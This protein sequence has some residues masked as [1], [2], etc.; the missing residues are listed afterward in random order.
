[1]TPPS[2]D[3]LAKTMAK[4]AWAAERASRAYA[5]AP[6]SADG[7]TLLR[8]YNDLKNARARAQAA[9]EAYFLA[10]EQA[11]AGAA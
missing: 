5:Q 9:A 2:L 11:E 6:F 8:L 10:A 3:Q 7:P 1:M 4:A